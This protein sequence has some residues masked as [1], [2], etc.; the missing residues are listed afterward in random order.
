[1][2]GNGIATAARL[3]TCRGRK[4]KLQGEEAAGTASHE[5][6]RADRVLLA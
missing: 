6:C 3:T 2:T 1:M 4:Q 5:G